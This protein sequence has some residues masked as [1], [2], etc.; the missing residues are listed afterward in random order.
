MFF[1]ILARGGSAAIEAADN[2][3]QFSAFPKPEKNEGDMR[4]K[5]RQ[6]EHNNMYQ[7]PGCR[8]SRQEQKTVSRDSN[9]IK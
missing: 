4:I 8:C 5:I 3:R 1:A 7:T 9:N 2:N 6:S